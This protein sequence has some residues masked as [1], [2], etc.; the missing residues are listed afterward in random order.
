MSKAPVASS[1]LVW[2][3]IKK[4]N[5]FQ[6][7]SVYNLKTFSTEKGNV[8]GISTPKYSGLS[9]AK[10]VDVAVVNGK[11]TL[12]VGA[13]S[14]AVNQVDAIVAKTKGVFYRGDLSKFAAKKQKLLE[15]GVTI[16]KQQAK[17]A[18]AAAAEEE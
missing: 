8:A 3:L 6:K 9:Q 16:S 5:S 15:R 11:T 18:A 17:A 12:T 2:L 4:H 14:T 7:K 1:D 10:T 13:E